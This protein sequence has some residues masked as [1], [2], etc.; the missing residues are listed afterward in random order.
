MHTLPWEGLM[1][2]RCLLSVDAPAS[3]TPPFASPHLPLTSEVSAK[4]PVPLTPA[5]W[6]FG[7]WGLIFALEGWGCVYQLSSSGYDADGFKV[8]N[9]QRRA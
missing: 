1:P 7:I 4:F 6:A 9:T 3:V 5:G 8:G 2:E